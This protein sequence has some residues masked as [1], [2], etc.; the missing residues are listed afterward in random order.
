MLVVASNAPRELVLDREP[1][2]YH[3]AAIPG[4]AVGDRYRFRLGDDPALYPDPASRY[5]PEGP[6][7]PSQLVDP[8]TFA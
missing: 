1:D 5:Q 8:S 6:F 4:L 3:S 2:G 7:G